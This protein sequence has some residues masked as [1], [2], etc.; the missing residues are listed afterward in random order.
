MWLWSF[1]IASVTPT[2]HVVLSYDLLLTLK[3]KRFKAT[4][5]LKFCPEF[6]DLFFIQKCFGVQSGKARILNT[7]FT[8]K[9]G[10]DACAR[11]IKAVGIPLGGSIK[12]FIV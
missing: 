7:I 9:E 3:I 11:L 5:F 1:L 6:Q 12:C 8:M 10:H 4:D 2:D